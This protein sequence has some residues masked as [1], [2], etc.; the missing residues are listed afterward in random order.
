VNVSESQS[1][2]GFIRFLNFIE[3][4][5]NRLPDP[6]MLFVYLAFFMI[7]LS[8]IVSAFGVTVI[9]PGTGKELPIKSLVSKEGIQYI[10]TSMLTNFTGFKPLGLVLAM[11]LGIGLAEKVGLLETAMK[12]SIVKA[13]RALITYAVLFVGIMGN[14]AS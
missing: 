11:M 3:R 1:S 5:G 4:V 7:L 14:L 6:F 9:H 13:P 2:K 12:K 10:L 8:W